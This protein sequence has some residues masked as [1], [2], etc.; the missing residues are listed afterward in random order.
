[1]TGALNKKS[2]LDLAQ[3]FAGFAIQQYDNLLAGSVGR[4]TSLYYKMEAVELELKARTG[5]QRDVLMSLYEHSNPNVRVKA[6]KATLA[7]APVAARQV[8]EDVAANCYG[9][10]KLEAGMSLTNLDRGIYKPV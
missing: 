5:D 6:A 10:E 3:V 2:S 7:I 4:A 8:L 1:M 9:P